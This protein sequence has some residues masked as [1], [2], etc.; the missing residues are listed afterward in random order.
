M[1]LSRLV[2]AHMASV[3]GVWAVVDGRRVMELGSPGAL[4]E[5]LNALV[6]AG[7][8]TA[9]AGLLAEDYVAEDE[10]LEHV[11][12]QLAL[13]DN[14]GQQIAVL[15]V[16]DVTVQPLASVS[17]EFAVAEGEGST[18]IDDWR[19]AHVGFWH[20]MGVKAS[21]ATPVVCVRFHV[22][23]EAGSQRSR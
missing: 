8:K 12:E 5:K 19:T 3:L 11:G 13:V 10:A 17:W 18:S 23:P 1:R 7:L 6:L 22:V 9:T 15:E 2:S 16:D 21:A 4:R 14:L 20:A